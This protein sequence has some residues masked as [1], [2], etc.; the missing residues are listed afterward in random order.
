MRMPGKT[1]IFLPLR[2]LRRSEVSPFSCPREI[3][4][5]LLKSASGAVIWASGFPAPGAVFCPREIHRAR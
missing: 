1:M 5:V 4:R 3:H 2:E